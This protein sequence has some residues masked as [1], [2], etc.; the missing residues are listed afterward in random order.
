[1]GFLNKGTILFSLLLGMAH[2][3]R[4]GELNF[5]LIFFFLLILTIFNLRLSK[6]ILPL[7]LIFLFFTWIEVSCTLISFR[8][9]AHMPWFRLVF[10]MFLVVL[11]TFL[12]LVFSWKNFEKVKDR[13][14]LLFIFLVVFGLLN[15][16]R[17]KSSFPLLLFDRFVFK[18]GI[19]QAFLLAL[20]G[21][22]VGER[23]LR[24]KEQYRL[25]PKIWALFSLVFFFQ[26]GLGLWVDGRFLLTG[27]LHF[28]IPALIIGG[29]LYRGGGFFMLGLFLSTLLLVGPAWC[30]HLCYVGGLDNWGANLQKRKSKAP[31]S[32]KG[33]WINLALVVLLALMG[34]YGVL[35]GQVLF[36]LVSIFG[37]VSLFFIVFW[38]YQ[39][40]KMTHCLGFCPLG[41]VSVFLG[42]VNPLRLRINLEKC[43][44]CGICQAKCLYQA[45][46]KWEDKFKIN[47]YCTNCLACFALCPHRAVELT[48]GSK[49]KKGLYKGYIFILV[50]LHT[51]FLGLARI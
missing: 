43:T 23:F 9:Q 21:V 26:L 30:S 41:L 19:F 50:S 18:L 3:F 51:L 35:E 38:S 42:K 13:F 1:M 37:L 32:R 20:Y 4:M 16:L 6:I 7:A 48:F 31:L 46:E 44:G 14:F 8:I 39:K 49:P 10:I 40:G 12:A 45:I 25:R 2:F 17:L 29:P 27:K 22:Y 28:P 47:H 24:P 15:F 36:F 34:R 5:V 33:A 11:F